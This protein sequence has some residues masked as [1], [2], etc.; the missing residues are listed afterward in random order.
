MSLDIRYL[1]NGKISLYE[2][3]PTDIRHLVVFTVDELYELIHDKPIIDEKSGT[4]Y[5]SI[6]CYEKEIDKTQG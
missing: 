2:E 5:M 1:I 4:M 3:I 6:D